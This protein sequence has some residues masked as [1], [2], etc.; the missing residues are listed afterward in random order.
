MEQQSPLAH[1]RSK[2][3][4]EKPKKKTTM[5]T[6]KKATAKPLPV[7]KE[8]TKEIEKQM[9]EKNKT[10]EKQEEKQETPKEQ[11]TD[12][13]P[14]TK[15]E[16]KKKETKKP[17]IVKKEEAIARGE[18]LPISKKHAMYLCSY[19]K[20][21]KID[22]SL[23]NLEKVTKLKKAI[24]FKGEIPHRKGNMER[25][26]YPV[27]AAGYFINILKG[28]RGNVITNQ[29]ELEETKIHFASASWANRPMRRGGRL[30]KRTNVIIK[31][32]EFPEKKKNKEGKK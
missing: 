12:S 20:N 10:G 16:E 2:M 3:T 32:K 13:K 1:R 4:E 21:R 28:L 9:E 24:P 5:K 6:T 26:R 23:T 27:K 29:M 19:I 15:P 30:A 11:T 14:E 22:D 31:A 8:K 25:G 7:D 18:N 17:A